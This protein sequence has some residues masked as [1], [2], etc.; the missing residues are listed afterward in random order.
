MAQEEVNAEQIAMKEAQLEEQKQEDEKKVKE[1]EADAE[2][3]RKEE[4]TKKKQEQEEYEKKMKEIENKIKKEKEEDAKHE[5]EMEK[6]K[7]EDEMKKKELERLEAEIK[8]KEE[9]EE[10]KRL[11]EKKTR[12]RERL[13]TTLD[14]LLPLVKEGNI[15]AEEL[16]KKYEF[17]P[18]IV[19][20]LDE[21]P[22]QSPL[23]ELKNS[24]SVVKVKVHNKED[25]YYYY[26]DPEKFTNR[27][28]MI[29]DI[30][31]E[32][33]E[34]GKKPSLDKEHDPFWDPREAVLIGKAYLYLQSLGYMVNNKMSCKIVNISMPGDHGTLDCEVAPTDETGD[35]DDCPEELY[36][37]KPEELL[38]RRIDFNIIVSKANNLPEM[39]CKDTYVKYSWYLDN[40]DFRT[41]IC[42]GVDKSPEWKYR[43]HMTIDCVTEDL[44]KY[45]D[46]DALT[47]SVYGTPTN[48]KFRKQLTK[49]E[50]EKKGTKD[51]AVDKKS[52][53]SKTIEVGKDK[54][55]VKSGEEDN[56]IE[57]GATNRFFEKAEVE[58]VKKTGC[59][60]IF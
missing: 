49:I 3:K 17:E 21:R 53:T 15:S 39:L 32:Y 56:L 51:K 28:Y 60:T 36:V 26:W 37:D 2:R 54:K 6:K 19:H 38:G 12:E 50:E 1:L 4:E 10:N 45:L 9:F 24:R 8:A 16:K 58:V 22:G 14:T 52:T 11:L 47:F 31:D 41:E 43:R 59:C 5:A 46:K 44:L 40:G 27:L 42:E 30:M 13:D 55:I 35:A 18:T 57:S 20:E 7:I 23:E 33:F 48:E 29:R 25:G 34:T